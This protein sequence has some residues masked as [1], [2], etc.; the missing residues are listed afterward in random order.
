MP[1]VKQHHIKRHKMNK[2]EFQSLLDRYFN[3][4]V[5]E[6][7]K[8]QL[9]EFYKNLQETEEGWDAIGEEKKAK[10]RVDIYKAIQ[11]KKHQPHHAPIKR[12]SFRLWRVAAVVIIAVGIA[13][14]YLSMHKEEKAIEYITKTTEEGQKSTITLSDGTLIKL[15]AKSSIRYPK[16]FGEKNRTVYLKG[17]AYFEVTHD[18][19]KP[20]TVTSYDIQTTVLGTSFNVRAYNPSSVSV[21]LVK[22]KVKVRAKDTTEF[23]SSEVYLSAGEGA[24]YD[25]T[26]GNLKIGKFHHKELTAWKDGIIYIQNASYKE[27]FNQL[28]HWYGVQFTYENIPTEEWQYSGEFKG[29]SL[30]LV[31]NTIGFSHGFSFQIQHNMVTIN[32]S[33]KN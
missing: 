32:F 15:N 18:P 21:A 33:N 8:Q 20:F 9:E 1:F 12:N 23:N 25:G 16:N 28:S 26:S 13:F 19:S 6:K 29:M 2:R 3:G 4:I 31:L 5:S 17:E 7:E 30:E 10:L 11:Q 22:G 27:V 24:F 14:T